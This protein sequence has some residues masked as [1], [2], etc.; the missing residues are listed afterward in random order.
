MP[1]LVPQVDSDWPVRVG[2]WIQPGQQQVRVGP[3]SRRS[4]AS[5][6]PAPTVLCGVADRRDASPTVGYLSP[7]N[8][9]GGVAVNGLTV[10]KVGGSLLALPELGPRLRK[11]LTGLAPSQVL[12]VPGGGPAADVV[13]DL[14][15]RHCL[16]EE[17]AHW[18]ALRA[19]SLNARVLAALVP[20]SR[21]VASVGEQFDGLQILDAYAFCLADERAHPDEA[22]PHAWAVTSDCVAARAA[23]AARARELILLKSVTIPKGL[24]WDEAAREGYVD[25]VFPDVIRNTALGVRA[26]NFRVEES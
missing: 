25:A 20:D 2:L 12:I 22:L 6:T 16:G 26:V 7:M 3:A 18:L 24:A 11:W 17:K 5:E 14:D 23:V 10:V 8:I 19:M 1:A 4:A 21:L 9:S 15:R 13:R